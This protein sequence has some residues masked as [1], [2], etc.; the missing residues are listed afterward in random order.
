MDHVYCC[1]REGGGGVDFS[2]NI[3]NKECV[4]MCRA[5]YTPAAVTNE[6]IIHGVAVVGEVPPT[7][8][9]GSLIWVT[10]GDTYTD[11]S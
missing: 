11:E 1:K 6:P 5:E 9:R 10:R 2:H 3:L 8:G 4:E 7:G